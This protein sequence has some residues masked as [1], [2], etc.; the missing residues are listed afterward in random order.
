MRWWNAVI[1][2]LLLITL[3]S[4]GCVGEEKLNDEM[5]ELVAGSISLIEREL[6]AITEITDQN[7]DLLS[8]KGLDSPDALTIMGDRLR[9]IP[10]AH[11]SLVIGADGVVISAV[12]E[13][14]AGIV[15]MDLS[16]QPAVRRAN[17]EQ[18]PIVSDLF[19][20]VEG[21][22]G[23]SQSSPIFDAD[24][25]YLGYT[26]ITYEPEILIRRVIT[27]LLWERP[28]DLWVTDTNGTI[29]YDTTAEEIGRNLFID[30]AY[31]TGNLQEVFM[32]IVSS[33]SG[34][35]EYTFWDR[36][37]GQEVR[38]E[39]VW[40]TAGVYGAEW[41][42]V[43]TRSIG[44]ERPDATLDLRPV[45][46]A[47]EIDAMR[48][49]VDDAA[50]YARLHGREEAAA[51]FNDP[52]GPFVD[53]ELYIFAYAMDGTTVALPFQQ[54]LIG[55]NRMAVTD[56]HG[57]RFIMDLIGMAERGGGS[58]YYIYPNPQ[59]EFRDELK[60]SYVTP[61]D[62]TWFVGSGIYLPGRA[63]A[64][65]QDEIDALTS[66]VHDARDGAMKLGREE[67]LAAFND[68]EREFAAGE[69]YIFAYGMD[70]TTLA[71]PFQPEVIGSDRSSFRDRF[72]VPVLLWEIDVAAR[73]GGFV[74]VTYHSPV[75]G[76]EGLK[77]CYVTPVDDAWF[78]GSGIYA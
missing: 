38:K 29:L 47:D 1:V 13:E 33:A 9:T 19:W 57:V 37:W 2:A 17:S 49:F 6:I 53:G 16:F 35:T 46:G 60:I 71:L 22:Y 50:A 62:E 5:E 65:S 54:G 58:L 26:D 61:V 11:S 20:L 4:A 34:S 14:Y 21:F 36:H 7:A 48:A 44:Q 40:G 68:Q 24:G 63:A 10:Y 30:P 18:V 31:Q 70:G 69:A 77:L 23:I 74:Y 72:G 43:T 42:V 28:Y 64:F 52:E 8:E 15:G 32:E 66:R 67:A 76:E 27:P 51:A 45:P 25:E 3:P 59:N 41:R 12:P 73:G 56:R 78:V 39:A 75:T 55:E